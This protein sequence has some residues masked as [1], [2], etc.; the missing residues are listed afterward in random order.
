MSA[1]PLPNV[2][3]E[4]GAFGA[5]RSIHVIREFCMLLERRPISLSGAWYKAR[6]WEDPHPPA[7]QEK[8]PA[9]PRPAAAQPAGRAS[10]RRRC[11]L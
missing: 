4:Q 2:G 3:P 5:A 9:D 11:R 7:P 6:V 1:F 10:R 8:G